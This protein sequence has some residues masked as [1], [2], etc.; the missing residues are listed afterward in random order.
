MRV[1]ILKLAG[2]LVLLGASAGSAHMANEHRDASVESSIRYLPSPD[3][4]R[5]ASFS[6][7]DLTADAEVSGLAQRALYGLDFDLRQVVNGLPV[8]GSGGR[9]HRLDHAD[10]ALSS[11][12]LGPNGLRGEDAE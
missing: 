7:E 3:V 8:P 9:V 4:M 1:W 2:L 6:Y 12:D 5:V 10:V 11:R